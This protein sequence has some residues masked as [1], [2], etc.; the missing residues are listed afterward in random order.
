LL[1]NYLIIQGLEIES[2]TWKLACFHYRGNVP[3][4]VIAHSK[5]TRRYTSKDV[6]GALFP[7]RAPRARSVE[8][9]KAGVRAYMKKRR[10]RG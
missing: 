6:H 9:M 1:F 5:I 2:C 8:Q 3:A 10:A 7:K 4:M